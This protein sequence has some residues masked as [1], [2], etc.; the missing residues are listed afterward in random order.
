MCP[1]DSSSVEISDRQPM[2]DCEFCQC[3][4]CHIITKAREEVSHQAAVP[5][6][7]GQPGQT[8]VLEKQCLAPQYETEKQPHGAPQTT[9]GVDVYSPSAGTTGGRR[10]MM[11]PHNT[12]NMSPLP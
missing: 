2:A 1:V 9:L 5:L 8:D 12:V 4:R 3:P 6:T 11:E 10:C 7:R